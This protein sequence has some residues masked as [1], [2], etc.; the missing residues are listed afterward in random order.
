MSIE[1]INWALT[2]PVGGNQKIV[3]LGLASHANP[4]GSDAYPSLDR[5]AVYGHCNRATVHRSLKKLEAAGLI[6]RDGKARR[7]T[8]RWTLAMGPFALS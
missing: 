2:A 4:D 8:V 6:V 5:L 7:G 1:A 3:L